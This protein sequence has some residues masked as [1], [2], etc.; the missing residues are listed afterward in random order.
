MI[1]DHFPATGAHDAAQDLSDLFNVFLRGDDLQDFDTRWD[2]APF[3]ASEI[4]TENVVE[5]L[6]KLKN[7]IRFSFRRY[8]QCTTKRSIEIKHNQAI[9]D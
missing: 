2:Q 7:T 5:G 1:Y 4:P 8:W 9:K 3:A 6:H